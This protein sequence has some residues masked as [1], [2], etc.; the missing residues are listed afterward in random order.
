VGPYIAGV[1]ID[2][3]NPHLLW[4]A[5]GF[6]GILSTFAFLALYRARSRQDQLLKA[7][8]EAAVL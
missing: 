4:Y 6:V 1:I 7:M 8:P 5:A 2:G 3:P